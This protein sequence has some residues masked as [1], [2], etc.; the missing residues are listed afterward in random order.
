[1]DSTVFFSSASI[2]FK[3]QIIGHC[4]NNLTK[5]KN[6]SNSYKNLNTVIL[7]KSCLFNLYLPKKKTFINILPWFKLYSNKHDMLYIEN[8]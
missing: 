4:K 3:F 1:M 6:L 5:L 8:W 2:K 7:H